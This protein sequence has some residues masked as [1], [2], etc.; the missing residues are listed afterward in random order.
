[1]GTEKIT[2]NRRLIMKVQIYWN[3]RKKLWSMRY[4]GKVIWHADEVVLHKCKFKVSEAGRQRV[5]RE[6]R[7]N[8]HA[9]VEGEL[10]HARGTDP[11][12]PVPS[13]KYTDCYRSHRFWQS[14]V[15]FPGGDAVTYNPYRDES[16]VTVE[17]HE[18][19]ATAQWVKMTVD[20][21]K[22]GV[23]ARS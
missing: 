19:V 5:L 11:S 15:K 16:F 17:G 3:I 8:V 10:C 18:P 20:G 14:D 21:D 12:V 13:G 7:K 1:V 4:K 6:N 9:V 2:L 23:L 22:P